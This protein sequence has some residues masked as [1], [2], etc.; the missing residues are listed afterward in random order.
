MVASSQGGVN[1]EEVARENPSAILKEPID[2]K[3]GMTRE[4][5]TKMAEQMGFSGN[6]AEQVCNGCYGVIISW[7][8]SLAT[9]N[10]LSI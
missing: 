9:H 3:T 8:F 2:I 5:A 7:N 1:I 4:Q 6:C 10:T